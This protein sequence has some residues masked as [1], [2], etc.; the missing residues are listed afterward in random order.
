VR[1]RWPVV[2]APAIAAAGACG[3]VALALRDLPLVVPIVAGAAV[4]AVSLWL[5]G[6]PSRLGLPPIRRLFGA[7]PG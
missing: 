7:H 3:A 4:Y 1:L 2:G 5:T 6:V